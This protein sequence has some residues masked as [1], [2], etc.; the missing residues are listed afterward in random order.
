MENVHLR[1]FFIPKQS[2][3]IK[4]GVL[5]VW[6]IRFSKGAL[7]LIDETLY[8]NDYTTKSLDTLLVFPHFIR[9]PLFQPPLFTFKI[10]LS[11]N[12][13]LDS[14]HNTYQF[15]PS[16]KLFSHINF[17]RRLHVK[18]IS[19]D[20]PFHPWGHAQLG[21]MFFEIKWVVTFPSWLGHLRLGQRKNNNFWP[22]Q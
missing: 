12:S 7:D 11:S 21:Q 1:L 13:N 19:I 5:T 14:S 6:R 4:V 2:F 16:Q 17:I 18:V 8:F 15:S 22:R 9:F 10:D 20:R 3:R